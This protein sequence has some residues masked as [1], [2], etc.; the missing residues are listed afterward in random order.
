MEAL[1]LEAELEKQRAS[2]TSVSAAAAAATP[3]P[4]AVA[5]GDAKKNSQAATSP[6]NTAGASVAV[7]GGSVRSRTA[8]HTGAA[9]HHGLPPSHGNH[10]PTR[11]TQA[12]YPATKKSMKMFI[13]VSLFL[14]GSKRRC[15]FEAIC[16]QQLPAGSVRGDDGGEGGPA[17]VRRVARLGNVNLLPV[18]IGGILPAAATTTTTPSSGSNGCPA[19]G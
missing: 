3:S 4:S 7:T 19:S 16:H 10:H 18:H 14:G 2:I 9:G 1:R 8:P 12:C 5:N 17:R 6:P 13:N 15:R 11:G